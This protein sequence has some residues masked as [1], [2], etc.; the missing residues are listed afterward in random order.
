MGGWLPPHDDS[1]TTRHVVCVKPLPEASHGLAHRI[2]H[3]TCSLFRLELRQLEL[4]LETACSTANMWLTT[5]RC[6]AVIQINRRC[7]DLNELAL[8][9]CYL[10]VSNLTRPTAHVHNMLTRCV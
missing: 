3:T 8:S 10:N 9:S 2:V 6:I 4:F 5:S 7:S 1:G